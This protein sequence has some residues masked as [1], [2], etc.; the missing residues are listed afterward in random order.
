M[1]RL[2]ERIFGEG[3]LRRGG[4]TA[5]PAGYQL[6]IYRE[7]QDRDGTLTPGGFVVEG[8]VIAAADDLRP[9]L[10]TPEPLTLRLDDGRVIDVYVVGEDGAV[11]G[12]DDAGPREGRL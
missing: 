7:W 3:E 2:V 9:W 10:F 11:S 5:L 1:L 4:D 12:A 6:A 8:H